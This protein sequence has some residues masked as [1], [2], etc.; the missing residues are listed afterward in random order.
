LIGRYLFNAFKLAVE[1]TGIIKSGFSCD[2]RKS[3]GSILDEM[4]TFP[5][6]QTLEKLKF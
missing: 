5:K 1:I 3:A 2:I 6:F 4:L